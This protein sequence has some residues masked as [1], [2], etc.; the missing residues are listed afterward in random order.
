MSSARLRQLAAETRALAGMEFEMIVPGVGSVDQDREMERD[1]GPDRRIRGIQ[2]I[3]DFF[4]DGEYNSRREVDRMVDGIWEDYMDSDW[5]GERKKE[6]WGNSAPGAIQDWF[7]DWL[8]S[9]GI[10]VMSDLENKMVG[11]ATWSR[12]VTRFYD[13]TW[14]YWNQNEDAEANIQ[15][16]ADDFAGAI[17][18]PVIASSDY[19]EARRDKTSYIVEPDGSLSPNDSDDAGLEFVSP[20]LPIDDL[21]SDLNKVKAWAK[22]KGAYTNKSTGLH[23]NV[24][25]P[26]YDSANLDYIKLALLAGD[27]YVLEQFGRSANT[28]ARSAMDKIMKNI[29]GRTEELPRLL[30]MMK[31]GMVTIA[32][33]SIHTGFTEKYTSINT[34]SGYVEFRSAGGDWLNAD[35]AKIENTLLR[36]VVA[37]DAAVHPEKYKQEYLKKFYQLLAPKTNNDPVAYFAR[38]A[39]GELPQS[40]L[41]SFIK[42]IQLQRQIKKQPQTGKDYWWEVKR[43]GEGVDGPGIEVVAGT[44]A[45]AKIIAAKHWGIPPEQLSQA[46]VK[47]LRVYTPIEAN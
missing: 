24:S 20:P 13:I 6:E 3:R 29:S 30:E 18:R 5:L 27:R 4:Y 21:L 12:S 33:K 22:K 43:D 10:A 19:H 7:T 39:A 44:A 8:E 35:V 23:I 46:S 25:I 38:Y 34:K 26:N 28:Y 36:F 37:L 11:G 17:D 31:Q 47:P 32:S 9:E 1:Y 41:K 14:P 42:Q 16:V 40:A 45:E 2:D 15:S